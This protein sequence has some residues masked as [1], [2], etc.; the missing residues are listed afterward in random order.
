MVRRTFPHVQFRMTTHD[1]LCLR[2]LEENEIIVFK[3]ILKEGKKIV[4]T[5][6]VPFQGDLKIDQILL[7][8]LFGLYSTLDPRHI[9]EINS[10]YKSS[11][12][13]NFKYFGYS[14]SEKM[15]LKI[16]D[17]AIQEKKIKI[18]EEVSKLDSEIE[19]AVLRLWGLD[20]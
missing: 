10:E 1:P 20:D 4:L 19:L 15:A 5:E 9:E 14:A 16:I 8:D 7:S 17:E 3:K 12:D 18:D 2:G 11:T 13:S 6:N